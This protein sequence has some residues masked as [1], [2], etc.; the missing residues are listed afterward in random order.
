M[1]S[2]FVKQWAE[3]NKKSDKTGL[4]LMI[5]LFSLLIWAMAGVTFLHAS[6]PDLLPEWAC[7]IANGVRWTYLT[8]LVGLGLFLFLAVVLQAIMLCVF[9]DHF[10]KKDLSKARD[11][12]DDQKNLIANRLT[13]KFTGWKLLDFLSSL[14]IV[15]LLFGGKAYLTGIV[16]LAFVVW[17]Q[18]ASAVLRGF[19]EAMAE[20]TITPANITWVE[21]SK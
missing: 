7:N 15:I 8:I 4:R 6:D 11:I 3:K 5:V 13:W 21:G 14:G 20:G 10:K 19:T 1:K 12:Y 17:T 9:S 16:L 18:F 2:E